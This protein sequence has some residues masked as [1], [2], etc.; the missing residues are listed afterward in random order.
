MIGG[1]HYGDLFA[2]VLGIV[3]AVVG[4]IGLIITA[5]FGKFKYFKLPYESAPGLSRGALI[6]V[7]FVPFLICFVIVKPTN[8]AVV[9]GSAFLVGM[10]LAVKNFRHFGRVFANN[11]YTKPTPAGC[12]FW[13]KIREDVI[14]GGTVLTPHAALLFSQ[15]VSMQNILAR[16]EYK[17][18]EVWVRSSRTEIQQ[19]IEIYYFLFFLFAITTV[20][21]STLS[22]QALIM[23]AAPLDAAITVWNKAHPTEKLSAKSPI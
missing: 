6:F 11:R 10:P 16:A 19:K 12:L 23:H 7:L 14:V 21:A 15:G 1:F 5:V 3:S 4:T 8:A 20:V 2:P 18:D 22:V 13:K 9:L 17:P